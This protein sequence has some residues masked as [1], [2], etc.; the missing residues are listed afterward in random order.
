MHSEHEYIPEVVV[1]AEL[2]TL[3]SDNDQ[4][5]SAHFG[6]LVTTGVLPN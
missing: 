5:L 3:R 2:F 6:I 1:S 4:L